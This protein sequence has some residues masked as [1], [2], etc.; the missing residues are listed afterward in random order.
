MAQTCSTSPWVAAHHGGWTEGVSDGIVVDSA[1][2][3]ISCAEGCAFFFLF[4]PAGGSCIR[5]GGR[6]ALRT[7]LTAVGGWE[8][9]P[10]IT[11]WKTFWQ[12][13]NCAYQDEP[14]WTVKSEPCKL[15]DSHRKGSLSG[16]GNSCIAQQRLR[17]GKHFA[18]WKN[19]ISQAVHRLISVCASAGSARDPE[20]TARWHWTFRLLRSP[21]GPPIPVTSN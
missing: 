2:A 3:L 12:D 7:A 13:D 8:Q 14:R 18:T 21:F 10:C 9:S 17:E 19:S 16:G 20:S 5:A 6:T 1:T 11:V 15:L 4:V